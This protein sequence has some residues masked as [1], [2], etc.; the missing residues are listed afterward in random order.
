MNTSTSLNGKTADRRQRDREFLQLY[1]QALELALTQRVPDAKRLAVTWT[2]YNSS[3]HY[4]VSYE[5]AYKVVRSLLNGSAQPLRDSLQLQMW[6]EIA[7]RV[8]M[9]RDRGKM[10]VAKALEFVLEHCRASRFFVTERYAYETLVDRA[11]REQ[12]AA[13]GFTSFTNKP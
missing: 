2:I 12:R 5:R 3:P 8:K 9:L 11:R 10:S 1:T 13:R 6:R 7:G 4:H